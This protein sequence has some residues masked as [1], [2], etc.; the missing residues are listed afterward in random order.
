[1]T[2][3][4][5]SSQNNGPGSAAGRRGRVGV[6]K[7]TDRRCVQ[8]QKKICQQFCCYLANL[9]TYRQPHIA[10]IRSKCTCSLCYLLASFDVALSP[11]CLC[12]CAFEYT[13]ANLKHVTYMHVPRT[14]QPAIFCSVGVLIVTSILYI[15]LLQIRF[16]PPSLRPAETNRTRRMWNTLIE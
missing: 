9:F 11:F 5:S 8:T 6:F 13:L 15:Y 2:P 10:I 7:T 16:V 1:M 4:G 12:S 3:S 14:R